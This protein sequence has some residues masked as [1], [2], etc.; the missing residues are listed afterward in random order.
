MSNIPENLNLFGTFLHH[1]SEGWWG[2]FGENL[3]QR[4]LSTDPL[5]KAD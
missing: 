1:E 5:R 4:K 2:T 3:R